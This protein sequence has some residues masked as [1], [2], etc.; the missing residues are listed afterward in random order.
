MMNLR[1]RWAQSPR[2]T[3]PSH[4]S[5]LEPTGQIRLGASSIHLMGQLNSILAKMIPPAVLKEKATAPR[6]RIERV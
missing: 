3:P 5:F 6:I 4:I 2:Y 1:F